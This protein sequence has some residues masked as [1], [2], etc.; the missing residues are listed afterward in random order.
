MSGGHTLSWKGL[1]G[2]RPTDGSVF[3]PD[4]LCPFDAV[5]LAKQTIPIGR[6]QAP[7]GDLFDIEPREDGKLFLF[8]E[9]LRLDRIAAG[10]RDGDMTISGDAGD[11]LGASMRGGVI[12]VLG[13][14]GHRVGGPDRGSDRGMSGGQI[15]IQEGV[16]DYVGL[17][18][19]KGS[20]TVRER[21]GR[22]P[23]YRM[24]AG[25]IALGRGPFDHP[26][27]E[28]RRG[29]LLLLDPSAP[30][31]ASPAFAEEGVFDTAAFPALTMMLHA[32]PIPRLLSENGG[33]PQRFRLFTGDR[34]ELNKGEIWQWVS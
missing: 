10:M 17:R 14:A 25:T 8:L 12:Q 13:G 29:T 7:L 34:F 9:D 26:G 27:A 21:V 19:R 3:R 1:P 18:M 30:P 22:S 6:E 5:T 16:G 32:L 31:V 11:D 2:A 15:L 33:W 23:G 24:L 20:I 4:L 28:M